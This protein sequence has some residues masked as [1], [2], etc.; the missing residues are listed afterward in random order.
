M[1]AAVSFPLLLLCLLSLFAACFASI[2]TDE[3][4]GHCELVRA[5]QL[6][7]SDTSATCANFAL[8]HTAHPNIVWEQNPYSSTAYFG[9]A[10]YAVG[11]TARNKTACCQGQSPVGPCAGTCVAAGCGDNILHCGRYDADGQCVAV[12]QCEV[13]A[14]YTYVFDSKLSGGVEVGVIVAVTV[15]GLVVLSAA[16]VGWWYRRRLSSS[17]AA[18][19]M[20]QQQQQPP[21]SAVEIGSSMYL[22]LDEP[23]VQ[24]SRS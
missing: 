13:P 6:Q 9:A 18:S 11:T 19:L 2:N 24:P 15:A 22:G 12:E 4:P 7:A 10:G 20:H 23:L 3:Y 8:Y 14:R 21:A 1:A 17:A 5:A 16:L